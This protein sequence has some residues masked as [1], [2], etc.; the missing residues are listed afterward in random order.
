MYICFSEKEQPVYTY[1]QIKNNNDNTVIFKQSGTSNTV[2][3][4]DKTY[5]INSGS[6]GIITIGWA[7]DATIKGDNTMWLLPITIKYI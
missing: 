3:S 2:E 5:T 6:N 4:F 7:Q 1:L